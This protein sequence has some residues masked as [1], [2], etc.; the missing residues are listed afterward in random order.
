MITGDFVVFG[1]A[2]GYSA[3][4]CLL[5]SRWYVAP[6]LAAKPK[7]QAL[8][9]LMWP[10]TC[11]FL[12]LASA[13]V[14]QVSPRRP[15]PWSLEIAWGDFAAAVLALCAIAA[16]RAGSKSAFALTWA[17]TVVGI[18]DFLNSFGQALVVDATNAPL[19]AVWFIAIGI[20]P[21][22]FTAHV[23]AIG[24]LRRPQ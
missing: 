16:L 9:A 6:A 3:L 8:L 14:H 11:R 20:V 10:H 24:V 19:G 1:V 13:T 15:Q 12:N 2:L 17:A 21:P 4:L 23:L 5:V 22:L 18:L 7:V